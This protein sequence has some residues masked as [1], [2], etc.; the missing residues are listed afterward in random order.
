MDIVVPGE[1][2]EERLDLFLRTRCSELSRARIQT[3]IKLGEVL[4]NGEQTRQAY[5]VQPGDEISIEIPPP[6]QLAVCAQDLPL[7]IVYEDADLLVVDKAAG[8]TV[9]PAPGAALPASDRHGPWPTRP[10]FRAAPEA[11]T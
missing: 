1:V 7:A 8:M 5:L 10:A 3:L 4:V 2:A 11:A 9:H 6:T